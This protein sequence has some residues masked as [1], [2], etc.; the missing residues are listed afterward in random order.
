MERNEV[1]VKN[2]SKYTKNSEDIHNLNVWVIMTVFMTGFSFRRDK[3][4]QV[5]K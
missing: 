2:M 4:I 1:R 5:N 3:V